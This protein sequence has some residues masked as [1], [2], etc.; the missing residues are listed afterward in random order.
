ME[1]NI[2]EII[3]SNL[4]SKQVVDLDINMLST[5]SVLCIKDSSYAI[6]GLVQDG[7]LSTLIDNL[8]NVSNYMNEVDA[9]LVDLQGGAEK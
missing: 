5:T 4:Q 3:D 2:Q 6:Y 9:E 7:G 1:N 8:R